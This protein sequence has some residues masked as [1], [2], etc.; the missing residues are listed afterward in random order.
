[1]CESASY[2]ASRTAFAQLN[3]IEEL[4]AKWESFYT[5][6]TTML[7]TYYA[8]GF[9]NQECK[10]LAMLVQAEQFAR[11]TRSR[12]VLCTS[13]QS[14]SAELGQKAYIV[15]LVSGRRLAAHLVQNMNRRRGVIAMA[16]AHRGVFDVS[17]AIEDDIQT[18][19]TYDRELYDTTAL[20]GYPRTGLASWSALPDVEIISRWLSA[21]LREQ[22]MAEEWYALT[23]VDADFMRSNYLLSEFVGEVETFCEERRKRKHD[24]RT[25]GEEALRL[26]ECFLSD[27]APLGT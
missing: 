23:M 13:S 7:P 8:N 10:Q 1:M 17:K 12:R 22:F 11:V 2:A 15:A 21:P 4:Y 3:S 27:G 14:G 20:T 25:A 6:A 18:Y 16:Q 24:K 26:F 19:V 9:L 5:S